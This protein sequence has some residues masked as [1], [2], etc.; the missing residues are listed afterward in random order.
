MSDLFIILPEINEDWVERHFSELLSDGS[1]V[2]H[3]RTSVNME[4]NIGVDGFADAFDKITDEEIESFYL[5]MNKY[6]IEAEFQSRDHVEAIFR[7][8]SLWN[9]KVSTIHQL[10]DYNQAIKDIVIYISETYARAW[11][12]HLGLLKED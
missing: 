3:C 6:E 10:Y 2:L 7:T 1:D 9:K 8:Y 11:A 12:K 5:G 4:H